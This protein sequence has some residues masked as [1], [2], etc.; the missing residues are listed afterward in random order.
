MAVTLTNS[1]LSAGLYSAFWNRAPDATGQNF[2]VNKLN[3][4][5]VTP[6]QMANAAFAAPEGFAAYPAWIRNDKTAL[7]T[8]VYNSVFN[9]AP[10][11]N[12]LAF[13]TAQ[14]TAD[15]LGNVTNFPEVVLG[16]MNSAIQSAAAGNT[17]GM[18]FL[19][20]IQVGI[21]VSEVLRTD[22]PA[23]TSVAFQGVSYDQASVAVRE[24]QLYEMANPPVTYT[25]T[26]NIDTINVTGQGANTVTGVQTGTTAASTT[27]NTGDTI[28]GNGLTKVNLVLNDAGAGT[29]NVAD[30]NN[31]AS[32]NVNLATNSTLVE[33][34]YTDVAQVIITNGTS[35]AQLDVTDA[36]LSTVHGMALA[37][38]NFVEVIDYATTT[39]SA[40]TALL[41]VAGT[42]VS[43]TSRSSIDVSDGNTVEAVELTTS[44][45]NYLTLDAGTAATSITVS[46]N[47]T[48]TLT[49]DSAA[50][51]FAL[52][53]SETTGTNSVDV[54]ALLS[55]GDT[56]TGGSGADTLKVTPVVGTTAAT[57]SGIETIQITGSTAN[58]YFSGV[59]TTGVATLNVVGDDENVNVVNLAATAT[60]I[61]LKTDIGA[62]NDDVTVTY[63]SGTSAAYTLNAGGEAGKAA[64]YGTV[65]IGNNKGVLT[66]V[67][68]IAA[69][70]GATDV[71]SLELNSNGYSTATV[72]AI[73]L[74]AT[75]VNS[76]DNGSTANLTINDNG[77]GTDATTVGIVTLTADAD[78]TVAFVATEDTAKA[79]TIDS[80]DATAADGSVTITLADLANATT[81]S[82]GAGE[83]TVVLTQGADTFNGGAGD[84]TVT[85][86][87]GADVLNLGAGVETIVMSTGQD[88]IQL[89]DFAVTGASKDVASFD[90]SGWSDPAG[91]NGTAIDAATD[92]ATIDDETVGAAWNYNVGNILVLEGTIANDTALETELETYGTMTSNLNATDDILVAYFDGY[93]AQLR[94]VSVTTA[95]V[96]GDITASTV[97]SGGAELV[98]INTTSL[99]DALFGFTA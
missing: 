38:R 1:Q 18:Q 70:G 75:G 87:G 98:A 28:N 4:G 19:N 29:G 36:V 44:G 31:V 46:G 12:G 67:N 76:S 5:A 17:D 73:A 97:V 3:T 43:A 26:T 77:T 50:T 59:N 79:L 16:M 8:Q 51:S 39:G 56:I 35:A 53:L 74:T 83:N 9:R 86:T 6:V 90:L 57:I 63:K 48:N 72:D 34:Q 30:V 55:N 10:D 7:V 33:S 94:V 24:A 14:L 45:V 2:W 41:S 96:S 71:S 42:G 89:F 23:I 85:T 21:F 11:A 13:W 58:A 27:Y 20:E 54:G 40:D 69:A 95:A 68:V 82:V 32:V 91:A 92:T 47:G 52:D 84:T 66:A 64:D 65:T 99:V 62:A 88:G 25:L 81:V 15:S 93:T 49:L 22:D 61:N 78:G 37:G 80:V 60:T